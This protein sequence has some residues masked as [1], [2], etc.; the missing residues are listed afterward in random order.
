MGEDLSFR[1]GLGSDAPGFEQP[2]S[3]VGGSAGT[4][5]GNGSTWKTPL[6]IGLIVAAVVLVVVAIALGIALGVMNSRLATVR[7]KLVQQGP[8]LA[9]GLG[10]V[11]STNTIP[12]PL[13]QFPVT[14]LA[15]S[16]T[17]YV[18]GKIMD[19][20]S[21]ERLKAQSEAAKVEAAGAST[22]AA[23]VAALQ[24]HHDPTPAPTPAPAQSQLQTPPTV[25]ASMQPPRV[26]TYARI[27]GNLQMPPVS[28]SRKVATMDPEQALAVAASLV[29]PPHNPLDAHFQHTW[30]ALPPAGGF[31]PAPTPTT[32]PPPPQQVPQTPT[33]AGQA[34]DPLGPLGVTA[35]EVLGM[36]GGPEV[37]AVIMVM[38]RCGA[39][40]RLKALL[41]DYL[42]AGKVNP[43]RVRLL[44][45]R[46]WVKVKDQLVTNSAP[47]VFRVGRG[48]IEKGPAGFPGDDAS[49]AALVEYL[50][51]A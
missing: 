3:Q 12:G 23:A 24:G 17:E 15:A 27:G 20:Q 44:E 32:A 38:G 8:A 51:F 26:P 46:E 37:F 30:G 34:P 40:T 31:H 21:A 2:G 5:T 1:T 25:L 42:Q 18:N 41:R 9:G 4:T 7:A 33:E 11:T 50:N 22:Q 14:G 43:A 35:E 6:T 13:T 49:A 48:G 28:E 45:D 39:C 29:A 19:V 36:V 47:Q 10:L 16:R